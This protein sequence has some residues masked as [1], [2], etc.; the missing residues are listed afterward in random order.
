VVGDLLQRLLGQD[1]RVRA[2]VLDVRR[3]VRPVRG[4]RRVASLAEELHPTVPPA[5][6]QPEAVD[7]D[8]RRLAGGV[9]RFDLLVLPLG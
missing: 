8:H 3:I 1:V 7:E 4:E 5:R 2:G 9:G 6:Q